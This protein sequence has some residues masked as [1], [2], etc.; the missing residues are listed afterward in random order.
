MN[1]VLKSV[2]RWGVTWC[3]AVF[4]RASLKISATEPARLGRTSENT[5][6]NH[7]SAEMRAWCLPTLSYSVRMCRNMMSEVLEICSSLLCW[8]CQCL[9]LKSIYM[10]W[11]HLSS[12]PRRIN[13]AFSCFR[14]S[15]LEKVQ[16]TPQWTAAAYSP[17]RALGN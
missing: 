6:P 16:R 9:C 8:H 12:R 2:Q 14:S 17:V 5:G 15:I 1:K 13:D 10:Y 7:L 4:H 3:R 11:L